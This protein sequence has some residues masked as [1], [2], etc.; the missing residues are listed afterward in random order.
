MSKKRRQQRLVDD[1]DGDPECEQDRASER[2]GGMFAD[3]VAEQRQHER[4]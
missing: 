3:F 1:P 2:P 4:N